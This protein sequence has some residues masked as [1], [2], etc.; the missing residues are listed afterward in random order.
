MRLCIGEN[1]LNRKFESIRERCGSLVWKIK[2]V[3]MLNEIFS[4]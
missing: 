1:M 3:C 4:A 2:I